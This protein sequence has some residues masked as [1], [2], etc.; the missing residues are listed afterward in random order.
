[1]LLNESNAPRVWE[2]ANAALAGNELDAHGILCKFRV[3][4]VCTTDDPTDSLA[5]HQVIA[6]SGLPTRVFPTFRPDKALTVH[7]PEVFVP[8]VDKL[9]IASDT[10]ISDLSS[11]EEALR[12]RHDFFHQMGGR[13]SDHGL[14]HAYA[15]F[16][17]EQE[18]RGIFG[19]ARQGHAATPEEH[20]RFAS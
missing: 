20:R 18:A 14:N 19:R 1:E 3:K 12:K 6:E 4:A 11:F 9:A 16:P 7:L 2:Q 17:S 13:L 15:D 10:D 5:Y 8:W